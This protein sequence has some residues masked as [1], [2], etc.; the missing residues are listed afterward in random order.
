MV[1]WE[2]RK[3]TLDNE[4]GKKKKVKYGM[5]LNERNATSKKG[6]KKAV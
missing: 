3:I 2:G 1:F 4:G 5:P 6:L